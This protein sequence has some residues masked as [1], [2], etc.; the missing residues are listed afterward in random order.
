VLAF[1][2]TLLGRLPS[3]D[4]QAYNC[5][6]L[7]LTALNFALSTIVYS[8]NGVWFVKIFGREIVGSLRIK[9]WCCFEYT[10]S[11]SYS[12]ADYRGNSGP[13]P[14]W[15]ATVVVVMNSGECLNNPCPSRGWVYRD[16]RELVK[17]NGC[18]SYVCFMLSTW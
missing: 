1:F 9:G 6:D 5:I 15:K 11:L 17:E 8:S 12:E 7:L 2:T 14:P 18:H 13:K 4:V 3:H 16:V 10:C